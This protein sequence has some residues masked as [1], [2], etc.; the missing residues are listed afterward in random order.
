MHGA[1]IGGR[2][3]RHG[4]Q[5]AAQ[6]ADKPV[7][8][9]LGRHPVA[10]LDLRHDLIAPQ[11]RALAAHQDQQDLELGGGQ[12]DLRATG[13]AGGGSAPTPASAP[14]VQPT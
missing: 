1:D 4:G 6:A 8:R 12:I 3:R 2:A 11:H 14:H 10:P 13:F 5:F 7:H 9:T